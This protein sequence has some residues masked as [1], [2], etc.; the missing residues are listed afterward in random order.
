M[1]QDAQ[2]LEYWQKDLTDTLVTSISVAMV[3]GHIVAYLGTEDGRHIQV[4]PARPT[5]TAD[6]ILYGRVGV[7][8]L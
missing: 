5:A 6:T 2:R 8:R 4:N 7:R 1:V 3:H